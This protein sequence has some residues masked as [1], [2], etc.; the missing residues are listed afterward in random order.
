MLT[1]CMDLKTLWNDYGIAGEVKVVI[2][3]L[4]T[5]SQQPA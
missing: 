4:Q 1:K 3:G 2:F 5:R